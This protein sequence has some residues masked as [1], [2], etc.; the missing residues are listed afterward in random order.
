MADSVVVWL[1]VSAVRPVAAEPLP[2]PE[3]ATVQ[4]AM[5]P[6]VRSSRAASPSAVA[7]LFRELSV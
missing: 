4:Y 5:A 3:P 1:T 6:A 7:R 2:V